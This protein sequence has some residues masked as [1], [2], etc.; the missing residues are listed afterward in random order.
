MVDVISEAKPDVT[1]IVPCYNGEEFLQECLASILSQ[2]GP[3]FEVLVIDDGSQNADHVEAICSSFRDPRVH[4]FRQEN[5]GVSAALNRGLQLAR[6]DV[7]CWLSHDDLFT[8]RRLETQWKAWQLG[9]GNRVLFGDF[10]VFGPEAKFPGVSRIGKYEYAIDLLAGGMING[11][12]VMA[13]VFSIKSLGY[14]DVNLRATQDYKMWLSLERAGFSFEYVPEV[15]CRT[16]IHSNQGSKTI[17]SVAQENQILWVDIAKRLDQ[18]YA[19]KRPSQR[20][21]R[22]KNLYDFIS[23]SDYLRPYGMAG[24]LRE[25]EILAADFDNE[26]STPREIIPMNEKEQK[27]GFISIQTR[28]KILKRLSQVRVFRLVFFEVQRHA[29]TRKISLWIMKQFGGG[30]W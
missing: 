19:Q 4:Y 18:V 30:S 6:A 28:Q 23:S 20:T 21:T 2:T 25:I 17:K 15:L 27:F 5:Q 12:T 10:E 11:C 1:V 22:M 9:H 8:P 13:N 14:F 3:T 26:A 16:R 7:F 24:V 29:S